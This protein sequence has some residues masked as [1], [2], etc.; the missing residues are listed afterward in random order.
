MTLRVKIKVRV[1]VYGY[2]WAP[3]RGVKKSALAPLGATPGLSFTFGAIF[4][5]DL[6]GQD[7]GQGWKIWVSMGARQG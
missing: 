1:G 2:Q 5:R 6:E 4:L 3:G 7:K